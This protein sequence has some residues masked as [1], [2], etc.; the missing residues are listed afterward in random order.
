ML[1]GDFRELLGHFQCWVHVAEG[2][3]E[4]QVVT[5]FG[6]VADNAL[7]VCTFGYVFHVA[8][9]NF[10]AKLLDQLLAT[11]LVLVGPAVVANWA[12]INEADFQRV[13]G[14]SAQGGAKA[15]GGNE[16]AQ[17]RF[18]ALLEHGRWN[19]DVCGY[20][21]VKQLPVG[22]QKADQLDN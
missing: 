20:V 9:F 4:N 2:G 15:K 21:V 18:F 5:A 16:G 1:K 11:L 10:V 12:D 8:G 17:Q 22:L 7:G 13:S 6:H 3:G 14:R 19:S